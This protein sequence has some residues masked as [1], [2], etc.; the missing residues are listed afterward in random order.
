MGGIPGTRRPRSGPKEGGTQLSYVEQQTTGGPSVSNP[1]D[2]PARLTQLDW[3]RVLAVLGVF[4]FHA[5]HPFDTFDWHVKNDQQSEAIS[6]LLAFLFPWGL[7]F[8]FLIAGAASFLALRT[9]T[10][11]QYLQERLLRLLVPY[12][13]GWFLLSPPQSYIEDVHKGLWAGTYLSFVP[14]FFA[15]AWREM[16]SWDE[17]LLPLPLGWSYHLW[18]LLYLFWFS[19]LGLPVFLA[20][21]RPRGRSLIQS[22][23]RL[24]HVRGFPLLFALP[25]ALLHIGVRA[26][27]PEEHA[28]GEF[29]YY[30]GFFILGYVL[31]AERRLVEAVR[32][33]FF[34][35]LLLG[36]TGFGLLITSGVIEWAEQWMEEPSYSW[37]YAGMFFLFSVQAVAWVFLVLS[38]GLRLRAFRRP[39]P[40]WPASTAMP[41]FVLHQPVI[42]AVAFVIVGTSFALPLK[43]V[44]VVGFSFVITTVIVALGVRLRA[45]RAVLGI[46]G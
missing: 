40:P 15:R 43:V 14:H 23:G 44:L 25:I 29:V 30:M 24:A 6:L 9:R 5:I 28:W 10:P 3:L 17:G 42:L 27:S 37:R 13:A 1:V 4:L 2:P 41:F 36:V 35:A 12:V 16:I 19:L 18:F 11:R 26:A 31:M 8:F 34:P 32:R 45:V 33:D 20:L 22:L 7:G 39:V 21:R 46:R 38:L